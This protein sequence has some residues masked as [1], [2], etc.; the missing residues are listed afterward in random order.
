MQGK[1]NYK[2]GKKFLWITRPKEPRGTSRHIPHFK[3]ET[4]F[5]QNTDSS[6]HVTVVTLHKL[7]S[8]SKFPVQVRCPLKM[9]CVLC[10]WCI[11]VNQW[12]N[13]EWIICT[14]QCSS[15]QFKG[16]PGSEQEVMSPPPH[17]PLRH[18]LPSS[19]F[20]VKGTLGPELRHQLED[21][22]P[23]R[24]SQPFAGL[25]KYFLAENFQ[26]TLYC[27][28]SLMQCHAFHRCLAI[29]LRCF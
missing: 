4:H 11:T 10:S 6:Q 27:I 19:S 17:H 14:T 18:I 25:S 28:F 13:L 7:H 8:A 29:Q 2:S 16:E 22:L 20:Q 23:A 26:N 3:Q 12:K 1:G 5:K 9:H 21:H 24:S 15:V